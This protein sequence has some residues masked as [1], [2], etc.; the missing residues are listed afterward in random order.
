MSLDVVYW[1]VKLDIPALLLI[2]L[3]FL[4]LHMFDVSFLMPAKCG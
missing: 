1:Y 2:R 4:T 3:G